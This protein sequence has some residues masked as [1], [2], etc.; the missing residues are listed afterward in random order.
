MQ[1]FAVIG[2]G[3][4]GSQLARALTRAGAEVIA[5]DKDPRLVDLL[6]SDVDVAVRLDSTDEHALREQGIDKVDVAVVGIGNDFE[7]NVLTTVTLKSMGVKHLCARAEQETHGRILKRIGAD[8]V[9]F[10]EDE[11]AQR[12]S[13]RLMAPQ[14][15]EK[16]EFAPGFSLGQYTAPAS[17]HGKTLLDLQLRKKY[18]VNLIGVRSLAAKGPE[19]DKDK[20]HML[21]IPQP[22]TVIQEGDILWLVGRDDDLTQLPV[23]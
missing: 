4:F 2:L 23:E 7:A 14:I 20:K 18:R 12:W 6:S 21:K 22:D 15:G 5:I 10:P 11:S 19:A 13:F 1:K 17:F 9:I 16:I 3:R 8:E